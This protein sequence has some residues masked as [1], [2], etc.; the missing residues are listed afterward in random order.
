M[1]TNDW[2]RRKTWTQDDQTEFFSR[3]RRARSH[4]KAQYLLIQASC[5]MDTGIKTNLQAALELLNLLIKEYP[6]PVQLENAYCQKALCLE[7]LNLMDDAVN[8]YRL[9]F[10]SRRATPNV[11]T[12]APLY[13]GMFVVRHNRTDL[14]GEVQ[15][16]FN[17]F[18]N[19]N[20]IIFPDAK[21]MYFA[22]SAI[23][24]D[25]YG[26][27]EIAQKCAERALLVASMNYSGFVRHPNVGLVKNRDKTIEKR[28]RKIL[29]PSILSRLINGIRT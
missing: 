12:Y 9:A 21:Y 8:F 23:I 20:E 5:L 25:S 17:E 24:A 13:F 7:S 1:K 27:L 14:Y 4:N 2:Y 10:R 18:I 22:T 15:E 3:F 28:L 19:N 6:H 11:H 29:K 16:R 26:Q